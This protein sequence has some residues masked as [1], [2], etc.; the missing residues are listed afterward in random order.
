MARFLITGATG[1]IGQALVPFLLSRNHTLV[2]LSRNPPSRSGDIEWRQGDLTRPETLAG[3]ADGCDAV[4]HLAGYAHATRG[5]PAAE[6]A[7]HRSINLEGTRAL[8]QL[9]GEAGRLP[10]IYI[11]SIK[12]M[13]HDPVDCLDE[14]HSLPPEDVYGEIKL[15]C[16]QA[17]HEYGKQH[18]A[19]VCVLRPSLVY[20]AKVK[21]NLAAML[22]AIDRGRFPPL[23]D[24]G[25]CRSMIDVRDVGR[26]ILAAYERPQARGQTIVLSDGECYSTYR[27]YT[28]L[29]RAL[30]RQPPGWQLPAWS[31]KLM[32]YAGEAL[33]HL[34]G[35]S[36]PINRAAVSR[37]L[38]SACYRSVR[39]EQC[40]GFAPQYRWEDALP[41]MVAAYRGQA[42]NEEDTGRLG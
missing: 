19:H 38:E 32:G 34:T 2:G 3:T 12:A 26:A 28:G 29:Y 14:D 1:F 16:E 41:G 11:S 25:N 35:R 4:L 40:L 6:G 23:P 33:E 36:L 10:F 8:L 22:R 9:A 42:G 30:G 13:G 37:L 39:F 5:H 21:G 15:A 20:G 7:R 24:T 27:L 18:D 31:L 17:V